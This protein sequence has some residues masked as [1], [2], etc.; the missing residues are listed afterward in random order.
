[1]AIY[2]CSKCIPTNVPD[3]MTL[4]QKNE[5]ASIVRD[6]S[7][8]MAMQKMRELLK[9]DLTDVKNITLH[10]TK[11]K[12]SCHHCKT[13]LVEYEGNCPKCERLNLDW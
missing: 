3:E 12:G 4:E 9:T 6:L 2:K 5:V 8:T 11:E 13:E 7:A 10:I 1:M